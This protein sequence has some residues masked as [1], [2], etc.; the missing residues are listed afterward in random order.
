MLQTGLVFFICFISVG[1]SQWIPLPA[2]IIAMIIMLLLL[3]FKLIKPSQIKE[4]S[5]FLLKNMTILFIPAAVEIINY[6]EYLKDNFLIFLLICL[7]TTIITFVVSAYTVI[8]VMQWQEKKKKS[9]NI[10]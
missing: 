2:T 10:E 1:L 8:F 9:N 5:D 7:I 6:T 4:Q 3:I